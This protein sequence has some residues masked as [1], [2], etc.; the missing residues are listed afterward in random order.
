MPDTTPPI[1]PAPVTLALRRR[2]A[3][4]ALGLSERT[5]CELVRE[6]RIPH[7]R[8]GSALLFPVSLL[9][10]WLEEEAAKEV[11]Q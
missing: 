3:A 10:R 9:V 5:V 11:Q 4:Q 8:I 2:E 6:N 7:L 1:S